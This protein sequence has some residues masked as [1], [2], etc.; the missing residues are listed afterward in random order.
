MIKTLKKLFKKEEPL[1]LCEQDAHITRHMTDD[2][3]FHPPIRPAIFTTSVPDSYI[4]EALRITGGFEGRG[5]GQV[6]GDFDKMGISV[7]VLQWNIGTGS[8]IRLL[9]LYRNLHGSIDALGI[10]PGRVDVIAS[11]SIA[12]ALGYCRS[13]MLVGKSLRPQWRAAWERFL[14]LPAMIECQTMSAGSIADHAARMSTDWGFSSMQAFCFMFDIVTQH[15]SMKNIQKPV[16]NRTL[17]FSY[18]SKADIKNRSV[19]TPL[20][21]DAMAEQLIL[22][23]AGYMRARKSNPKYFEDVFSRKGTIALGRGV[24]HGRSWLLFPPISPKT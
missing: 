7:G 10:F 13:H 17:A 22:F 18:A 14:V 8:L 3:E 5:F 15:G 1:P 2:G 20:V 24:V 4:K 23:Q 19:W 21:N 11:A 9:A 16:A 6:T 12:G